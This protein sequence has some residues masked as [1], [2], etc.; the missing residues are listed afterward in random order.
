MFIVHELWLSF[1]LSIFVFFTLTRPEAIFLDITSLAKVFP[2]RG[3]GNTILSEIAIELQVALA[4]VRKWVFSWPN[5][6]FTASVI[7]EMVPS[8]A[9]SDISQV[10]AV[11]FQIH[12]TSICERIG[13]G[14]DAVTERFVHAII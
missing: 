5:S 2:S 4:G 14:P 9:L 12:L 3:F 1:E 11:D 13:A 6:Q 10:C 7:V 8:V